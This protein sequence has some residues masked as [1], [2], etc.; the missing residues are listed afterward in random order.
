MTRTFT[1]IGKPCVVLDNMANR[2]VIELAHTVKLPWGTVRRNY[3]IFELIS[4]REVKGKES[5]K[6]KTWT[7]IKLRSYVHLLYF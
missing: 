1:K 3:K 2:V 4:D 6:I 5:E 7:Q